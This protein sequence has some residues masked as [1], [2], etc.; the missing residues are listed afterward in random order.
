M[1]QTITAPHAATA[2]KS[3]HAGILAA[4]VEAILQW[5]DSSDQNESRGSTESIGGT[6]QP[7]NLPMADEPGNDS[8]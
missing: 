3:T 1:K 4:V 8:L 2:I 7:A 6:T 5:E